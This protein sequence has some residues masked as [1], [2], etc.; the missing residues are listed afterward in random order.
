MIGDETTMRLNTRTYTTVTKSRTYFYS[1]TKMK[2]IVNIYAY[3]CYQILVER[4]QLSV[5]SVNDAFAYYIMLRINL[6]L[7]TYLIGKETCDRDIIWKAWDVNVLY[8]VHFVE[9]FCRA[10]SSLLLLLF[11]VESA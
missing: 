3:E 6:E 8:T 2:L 11:T 9:N 10:K 4:V 5:D 1:N 7:G